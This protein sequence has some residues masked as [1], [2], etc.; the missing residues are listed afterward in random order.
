VVAAAIVVAA[1]VAVLA[2]GIASA[3]AQTDETARTDQPVTEQPAAEQPAAEQPAAEQPAAEQPA[4]DQPL[5]DQPPPD[6]K[7]A[8][9]KRKL[10]LEPPRLSGY[11]QAHYRHAFETGDDSVVDYNDFR[12]QRVR[13]GIEGDVFPWLS[14][15]LE[16]D[17]RAP[18][19]TGI[20]RDAFITFK[21]IPRH[22]LRI[23]QQKMQF[24]YE[25]VES[26]TRLYAVNRTEVSD[27]L[28]RGVNLRDVGVGLIGNWKL[29]GGFRIEDALTVGNGA[30]L[31]V[32]ADD[33]AMKNVWGR[34]GVRYKRDDLGALVARLG[35]SGAIGDLIDEGDDEVD[36]ADDFRLELKR[37][38]LD[39]EVDHRWF[40]LSA[41][42]VMGW[43]E[44]TVTGESDDPSGYYVNLVGKT[45]WRVGP[46]VRFD[47]LGDEY[48]RLTLGGFYALPDEPLR[49]LVNHEIRLTKDD[50]RGDDKLYVWVQ[51]AF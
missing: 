5:P 17:P 8:A 33:T 29:G 18:E 4:A 45:R 27:N 19:I 42:Y 35:V 15:D 30:G 13:F 44:N 28:S 34:I 2:C 24:G 6:E 9:R 43:D 37:L 49:V 31:N 7:A 46:I 1:A 48:Q 16:V 3:Q 40:F 10:R 51:V 41:E 36:P 50:V 23:G 21:V 20:L 32:Q 25:N 38:G 39:L 47:T 14:Y 11:I 22:R 12:V 26:S